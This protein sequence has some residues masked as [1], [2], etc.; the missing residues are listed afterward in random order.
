MNKWK[1]ISV[2]KIIANNKLSTRALV[3]AAIFAAMNIILTRA[4]VIMLFGGLVR[5]SFGKI[6]LI[7]SGLFLGPLAG[8]FAGLVGDVLGVIINSHGAP[9]I[10]PGFTLSSVLTGAVPGII[11]VLSR[12]NRSSLFNV[13][14]SNIVVL[15]LVN[16][17]LD[18]LWL[19]QMYGNPYAVVFKTRL[20]P[21][22]IIAAINIVVT[23]PL[24]KSLIKTGLASDTVRIA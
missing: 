19:S 18:T 23:Y 5:L 11:V 7:L 22:I 20:I 17:L 8:A 13:I 3:L 1:N 14:T 2:R 15:I 12:K 24:I 4:G 9:M 6:P 16:L 21:H 10:H